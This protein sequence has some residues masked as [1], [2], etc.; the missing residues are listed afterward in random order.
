MDNATISADNKVLFAARKF[1]EAKRTNRKIYVL[2]RREHQYI[3]PNTVLFSNYFNYSSLF[4]I[5]LAMAQTH[6]HTHIYIV[7]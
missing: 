7:I 5:V 4:F 3:F 6:T 2:S 1:N